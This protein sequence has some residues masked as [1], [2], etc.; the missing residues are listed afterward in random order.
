MLLLFIHSTKILSIYYMPRE[1]NKR[2]KYN[3]DNAYG[4][5]QL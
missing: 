5:K 2:I 1:E 3:E 4:L